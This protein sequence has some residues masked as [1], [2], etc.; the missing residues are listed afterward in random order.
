MEKLTIK[1][2]APYLPHK[3]IMYS[4][5][6]KLGGRFKLPLNC[7]RFNDEGELVDSFYK[8]GLRPLSD[9]TKEIEH[10]GEKV[11]P[12][13]RLIKEDKSFTPDFIHA[14]GYEELKVSVFE[15][16]LEYHFDVFGLIEKGLAVELSNKLK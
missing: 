10:N 8:P 1:E 9:L 11:I 2:L 6:N 5:E 12:L 3:V 14:F 13:Y 15:L 16:L 4:P 7:R